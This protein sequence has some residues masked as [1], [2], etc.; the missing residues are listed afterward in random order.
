MRRTV[1]G[2]LLLLLAGISMAAWYA[3]D[4]G[5]TKK[6]RAY[7]SEEFRKAGVEVSLRRL[8][9]DP[10]RGLVAR[11][12]KVFDARDHRR[13]LAQIDEV[14]LGINYSNALRGQP[15][16]DF[17]DLRDTHLALPL[18]SKDPR[19]PKIEVSQLNARLFLPPQQVYLA[20]AEAEI[21]GVQVY[22]TGRLINPQALAKSGGGIVL[23]KELIARVIEEVKALQ[24]EAEPPVLRL[25]GS[26]DLAKPEEIF[27]EA[28]LSGAAVRRQNYRLATFDLA[29]AMR[30]GTVELQR[31][32]ATDGRGELHAQGS[33]DPATRK[34][35]LQLRS[36]LDLQELT[37]AFELAPQ[38]GEFVFYDPPALELTAE[39]T[40][41]DTPRFRLLGHA[42]LGRFAFQSVMFESLA[43]DGSWDGERWSVRDARLTHRSGTLAGDAMRVP[44]DFRARLRSTLNPR[45][46][47]PL[48]SGRASEWLAQFDF[49]ESPQITAELSGSAPDLDGCT[50]TAELSAG[51]AS[52]RGVP[53]Q[54]ATATARYADHVL[55]LAPFLVQ[56]AEGAGSGGIAIDC[57]RDEVRLDHLRLQLHPTVIAPWISRDLVEALAPFRFGDAPPELRIDGVVHT[58]G[59][60]TTKLAV[61]VSAPGS[62]ECALFGKDLPLSQLSAKLAFTSRELLI[63]EFSASLFGGTVRG[64]ADISLSQEAPGHRA[65]VRLEHLDFASLAKLY[66][67]SDT[68]QGQL[69]GT[70]HFTGCGADARAVEGAGELAVSEGDVFALPTFQPFSGILESIAPGSGSTGARKASASFT[71]REGA[72]ATENLAVTGAGF[73]LSGKGRLLFVEDRIDLSLRIDAPLPPGG[74]P[75]EYISDG[76]FSEPK[77]RPLS[78]ER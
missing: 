60:E 28:R 61:E 45:A 44:G 65:Q 40:L 16:L 24:A 74:K 18:D 22:A 38:L 9:L 47:L 26:G 62:V 72:V 68:S 77:W 46:L 35:T 75:S 23:P 78:V 54:R 25:Q 20:R 53:V 41:G 27:A 8:T 15:F 33:F 57:Q 59:G 29:L 13:V 36:S 10:F 34:A 14:N 4:K 43:A 17:I 30:A 19:G 73:S 63:R 55:T 2:L 39:G 11:E 67:N 52:Y 64:E 69:D 51:K 7:V 1:F 3:Y 49:T 5:F 50:A 76:K 66:F 31:L 37:R 32:Q 48:F 58:R 70:Y 12:V 56:R 71:V 6:W 21:Y 42:A